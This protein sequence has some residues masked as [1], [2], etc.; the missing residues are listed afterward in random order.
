M[1][2]KGLPPLSKEEYVVL[3]E[4]T[5]SMGEQLS[6]DAI[7]A[8]FDEVVD[9]TTT[10]TFDVDDHSRHKQDA[11]DIMQTNQMNVALRQEKRIQP[12]RLERMKHQ[13]HHSYSHHATSRS[14]YQSHNRLHQHHQKPKAAKTDLWMLRTDIFC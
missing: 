10:R 11:H 4:E 2:P 12:Q 1:V 13:Q 9:S 8:A 5:K 7:Q 6:Q 3:Q 14:H